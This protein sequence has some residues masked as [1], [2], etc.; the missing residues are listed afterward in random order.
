MT[1]LR[2]PWLRRIIYVIAAGLALVRFANR[3]HS[4]PLP[5]DDPI[6]RSV[7]ASQTR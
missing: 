7:A 6:P 3:S 1:F 2:S 5:I 4:E